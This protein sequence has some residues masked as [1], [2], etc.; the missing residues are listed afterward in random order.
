MAVRLGCCHKKKRFRKIFVSLLEGVLGSQIGNTVENIALE[1]FRWQD[2]K[3]VI[4][5]YITIF[6]IFE[7]E[8]NSILHKDDSWSRT[9]QL[10]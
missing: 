3:N 2:R 4:I 7:N 1:K 10:H 5:F 8:F 9:V 6:T